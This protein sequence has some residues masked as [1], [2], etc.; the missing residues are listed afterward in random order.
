MSKATES[1]VWPFC[2]EELV[3]LVGLLGRAH[4]GELAHGPELA[5]VHRRVDAAGVG[6][7]AREAQIGSRPSRS[8]AVVLGVER[9]EGVARERGEVGVP[10][11]ELA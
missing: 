7:F 8:R 11:L 10:E 5:P 2:Q 1:P 3:A 4:A 6:I 9:L